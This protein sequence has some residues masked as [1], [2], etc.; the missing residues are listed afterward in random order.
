MTWH[1]RIVRACK[2]SIEHSKLSNSHIKATIKYIR[3]M[4][5]TRRED[6]SA[7]FPPSRLQPARLNRYTILELAHLPN[8]EREVMVEDWLESVY[9]K[10]VAAAKAISE[11]PARIQEIHDLD[12]LLEKCSM[13]KILPN[14]G[15]VPASRPPTSTER[16][17][18][19]DVDTEMVERKIYKWRKWATESV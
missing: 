1:D 11:V 13:G 16:S 7:S 18:L 2:H 15:R 5:I 17:P 6:T 9:G 3:D 14:E 12:I 10:A 8:M 19:C 4:E